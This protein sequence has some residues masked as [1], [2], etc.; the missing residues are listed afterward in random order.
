MMIMTVDTP[1]TNVSTFSTSMA[2]VTLTMMGIS[3]IRTS[4]MRAAGTAK[5]NFANRAKAMMMMMMIM[6]VDTPATNVSTFSTSMADVTLTKMGIS[7]IRTSRMRAAGTAKR[8]FANR[9]KAVMMTMA[10]VKRV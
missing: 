6:T 7:K 8:N 10:P 2:D 9:A 5:R 3:K 1:A 4:R